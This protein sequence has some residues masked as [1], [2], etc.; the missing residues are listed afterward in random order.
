M[1]I[2]LATWDDTREAMSL[3][4][5]DALSRGVRPPDRFNLL[6]ER[7]M[8]LPKELRAQA[9]QE[10][11]PV[12]WTDQHWW[13]NDSHGADPAGGRRQHDLRAGSVTTW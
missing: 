2:G 9:P 13:E 11:G 1:N 8:G 12:L 3:I 4:Y 7:R 6:A 10:T 5:E